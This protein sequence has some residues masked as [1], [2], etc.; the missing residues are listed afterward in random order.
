MKDFMGWFDVVGLLG[1]MFLFVVVLVVGL[2]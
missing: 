2:A 1:P